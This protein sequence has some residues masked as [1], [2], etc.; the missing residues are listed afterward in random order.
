[1]KT[2]KNVRFISQ[3][4]FVLVGKCTKLFLDTIIE[5]PVDGGTGYNLGLVSIVDVIPTCVCSYD[6]YSTALKPDVFHKFVAIKCNYIE[7][8]Y[9]WIAGCVRGWK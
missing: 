5:G 9:L 2:L 4:K 3:T 7:I 6:L 1:M 8:R